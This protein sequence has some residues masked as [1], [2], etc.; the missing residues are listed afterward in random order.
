MARPWSIPYNYNRAHHNCRPRW[1]GDGAYETSITD[2][3]HLLPVIVPQMLVMPIRAYDIV[4]P[5]T[6]VR[7]P[8]F[9]I[10]EVDWAG[11]L[12]TIFVRTQLAKGV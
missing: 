4:L 9:R 5:N 12:W 8:Y 2:A 7:I 6:M 10:Q 11:S 1:L 3:V